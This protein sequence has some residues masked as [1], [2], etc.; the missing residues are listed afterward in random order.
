MEPIL[1]AFLDDAP[2][3]MERLNLAM[4]EKEITEIQSAAHAMK[5]ASGTIKADALA[6]LLRQ[7]EEA[8]R[9]DDL[10]CATGLHDRVRHEYDTVMVYLERARDG[11]S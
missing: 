10:E 7:V 6:D 2:Q 4:A 11:R 5:G 9:T 8:A 3:S 1:T